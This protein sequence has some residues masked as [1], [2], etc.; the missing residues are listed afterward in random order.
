MNVEYIPYRNV[1]DFKK[2]KSCTELKS[3]LINPSTSTSL[4]YT[5]K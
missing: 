2:R 4:N 3:Y 1:R 5:D